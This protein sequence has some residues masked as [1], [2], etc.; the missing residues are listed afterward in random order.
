M[1]ADGITV[2]PSVRQNV[3]FESC[4]F[5]DLVYSELENGVGGTKFANPLE[6]AST[7]IWAG[8]E[9]NIVIVRDSVFRRNKV[10]GAVRRRTGCSKSRVSVSH[11][12][13]LFGSFLDQRLPLQAPK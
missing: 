4:I 9:S 10:Q 1:D 13:L 6:D 8:D 11:E 5:E 2:D 12:F 3:T 7:I